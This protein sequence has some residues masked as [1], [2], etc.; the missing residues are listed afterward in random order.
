[1]FDIATAKPLEEEK[2]KKF[3]ITTAK[4]VGEKPVL[5]ST[6][7]G[8]SEFPLSKSFISDPLKGISPASLAKEGKFKQAAALQTLYD[9]YK[10][11]ISPVLSG[12]STYAFGIPKGAERLVSE[13]LGVEPSLYPEQKTKIGKGIRI[14]SEIT[15]LFKGGAAKAGQKITAKVPYLAGK[16][17][18]PRVARGA[19]EG[20]TFGALQDPLGWMKPKEKAKET[21]TYGALGA[22]IPVAGNIAK[23]PF[24]IIAKSGRWVAKN[25]GGITDATIKTIKDL[26]VNR[27]FDPKKA[28]ADYIS[29]E[30]APQVYGKLKGFVDL[31]DDAYKT[32]IKNAPEGKK[33]NVRPAIEEAGKR[34]K[35]LGLITERGNM[36]ELGKSE[37]ARDS[38]YGKMLDFYK[39]ADAISGVKK[40]QGKALTN[41]QILKSFSALRETNV[42]KEQYLFLRDKLNA[43]YKNKPS[44]I[45][46]SKVVNQFYQDGENAGIKGLQEARALQRKVFEIEDKIDVNKIARNLIKAKNPQWTRVVEKEYKDLVGKGIITE[47][48]YQNLWDDLMAHFANIDFELVGE[49]PGAGGGFYPSRAG[50][51][52]QAVIGVSKKYYQNIDPTIQK[53]KDAFPETPTATWVAVK[54]LLEQQEEKRS[55][56]PKQKE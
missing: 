17:L 2:I 3:D 45:D 24:Q 50:L 16:T 42:N 25:I 28:N 52:R 31:A 33:I 56:L 40:L 51:A 18:L 34:L 53:L 11:T 32:A 55:V 41:K 13:K 23:K 29:Q 43:L 15:G 54:R 37:I 10:E 46:V 30:L 44:D 21:A 6:Y 4:K 47:K 19:V 48:E 35:A 27:V 39:S 5:P 12:L 22:A 36:T 38:V 8:L 14:G 9:M 26:G 7:E 49:T 1:M 20:A